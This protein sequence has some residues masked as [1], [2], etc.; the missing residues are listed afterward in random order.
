MV[1]KIKLGYLDI[2]YLTKTTDL[3]Q[4]ISDA[5]STINDAMLQQAYQKSFMC[6]LYK[7]WHPCTKRY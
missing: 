6:A 2:T 1:N 7:Q 5:S 4:R 3:K